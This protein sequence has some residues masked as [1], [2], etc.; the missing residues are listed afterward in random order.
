MKIFFPYETRDGQQ[1]AIDFITSNLGRNICI[2]AS[3]GF[4][5]TPVIL[6]TLLP[7]TEKGDK[8]IWLS[9]TGTETDRPIEELKTINEKFGT[10]LFGLSFRGKKDMCLLIKDEDIPDPEHADVNY[11]CKAKKRTCEYYANLKEGMDDFLMQDSPKSFSELL[12]FAKDN[13]ICPYFLQYYLLSHADVL[14][15]NYNQILN[16]E[17]SFA[18]NSMMPFGKSFLVVDEAHNLQFFASGMNSRRFS[19]G[20]IENSVK[21]AFKLEERDSKFVAEYLESFREK[22]EDECRNYKGEDEFA[23]NDFL[24]KIDIREF[25]GMLS[26]IRD[27][28]NKVRRRQ[29]NEGKLP[30]SSL[31]HFASFWE[32][33]LDNK[34]T[35]GV[36][37]VIYNGEGKPLLEMWDMRCRETL[38]D[39][40]GRFKSVVFSSGTLEPMDAFAEVIGLEDYA[41][42]SFRLPYEDGNVKSVIVKG[43]TT[44]GERMSEEMKGAYLGAMKDFVKAIDGNVII[45]SASYRIQNELLAGIRKIAEDFGRRC[46][47]EQKG[48]DGDSAARM[49]NEYK[50]CATKKEKGVLCA[51]MQGRFA[52]GVDLPGREVDAIF[53]VGIP[54]DSV[55][56]KTKLYLRYYQQV[57]G[58]EKG[59]YYAYVVPALRRVSQALGRALRSKDDKVVF[60]LGDQRYLYRKYLELLPAFV[61]DTFKI[62][63]LQDFGDRIVDCAKIL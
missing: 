15:I 37:F 59:K 50:A 9:R 39:R 57:Y 26:T 18:I 27:F 25:S 28:G 13:S 41:G 42:R 2:N 11:F 62:T 43:L 14:S 31:Y 20:S 23:I 3:T 53:V 24:K 52:E 46:F 47:V 7:H 45:F 58:D 10:K 32:A 55:S 29:L 49:L 51:T 54:F 19:V 21:E 1:E 22:I 44:K 12:K 63:N 8:V 40:W 4:G 6:S 36:A 38:K 30:H 48:M 16:E 34:E 33:A 61:K 35:N 56:I 17:M 60:V 5:K